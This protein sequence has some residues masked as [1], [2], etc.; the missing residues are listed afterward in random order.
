MGFFYI[1]LAFSLVKIVLGNYDV[2]CL[3]PATMPEPLEVQFQLNKFGSQMA[4]VAKIET[5][6]VIR[7][8]HVNSVCAANCVAYHDP[9]M[10][11][12]LTRTHPPFRVE[13]FGQNK[14]SRALCTA[15][16]FA[17]LQP[18]GFYQQFW[19]AW[20]LTSIQNT[21]EPT[22]LGA[23]FTSPAAVAAL[24]VDRNFDPFTVGQLVALEIGQFFADDGWNGDGA[25][26]YDPNTETTVP[27]M[28][29]C[30]PYSDITGYI[31]KKLPPKI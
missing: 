2:G 27:C 21:F 28:A 11:N 9:L 17:L 14:Y 29:N 3:Y 6:I 12:V 16:C 30:Q 7:G 15:Q 23:A 22:V 18:S 1:S 26:R 5:P 20:G 24:L 19:D 8:A 31:P 13:S 25:L 4:I 10:F